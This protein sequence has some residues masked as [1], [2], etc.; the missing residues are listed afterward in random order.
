MA[1]PDGSRGR[2]RD[3]RGRLVTQ[4]DPVMLHV[5]HR[6]NVI[7]ADALD[8]IVEDLEPGTARIRRNLI[9]IIPCVILLA[10]ARGMPV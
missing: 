1:E 5:L 9:V 4:L 2:I 10:V 3:A 7:E 6:H 8:E